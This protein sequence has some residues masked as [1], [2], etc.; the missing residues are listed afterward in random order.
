MLFTISYCVLF[1]H[2]CKFA[3]LPWR[4]FKHS[5]PF[6]TEEN[7]GSSPAT[8]D[9][10]KWDAHQCAALSI[11]KP[12]H[13]ADFTSTKTLFVVTAWIQIQSSA[14]V[15]NLNF[16][17]KLD[18]HSPFFTPDWI[19]FIVS[20][21]GF[22]P[23]NMGGTSWNLPSGKLDHQRFASCN[24]HPSRRKTQNWMRFTEIYIW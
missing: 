4:S 1:H 12:S 2:S 15:L 23:P 9:M 3:T 10:L 8:S 20:I 21:Y 5:T 24:K 6:K 16:H 22:S 19:T 17:R 14:P 13:F 18:L 7:W 11:I